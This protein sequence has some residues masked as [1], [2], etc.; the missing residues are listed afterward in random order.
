MSDWALFWGVAALLCAAYALHGGWLAQRWG[1]DPSR[2]TKESPCRKSAGKHVFVWLFVLEL[3]IVLLAF[4][5][6]VFGFACHLYGDAVGTAMGI[7]YVVLC[8][9]MGFAV[10]FVCVRTNMDLAHLAKDELFE[11]T[12]DLICFL[13][14]VIAASLAG[15]MMKMAYLTISAE[16][17]LV[18]GSVAWLVM[19][20]MGISH[21]MA[22]IISNERYIQPI[23]YGGVVSLG[24]LAMAGHTAWER[25]KALA[26]L[27]AA[28]GVL[29][30]TFL[31]CSILLPIQLGGDAIRGLLRSELPKKKKAPD[32]VWTTVSAMLGIAMAFVPKVWMLTISLL[33]GACYVLLTT[34]T[35][36]KWF[37]RMGRGLFSRI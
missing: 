35:C 26:E 14:I 8:S 29:I 10:L 36:T 22:D 4:M 18:W 1:V 25:M 6:C 13:E 30:I 23:A 5:V 17:F 28:G 19:F 21:R 27:P 24:V 32:L 9:A 31:I 15:S 34:I 2:R 20:M 11:D 7:L 12:K 37:Y 16:H 3:M 33:A